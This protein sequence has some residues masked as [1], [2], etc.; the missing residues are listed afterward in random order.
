MHHKEI[1]QADMHSPRQELSNG[2]LEFVAALTF[3]SG[4]DFSCVYT[5]G[6]TIQLYSL[7]LKT[8]LRVRKDYS[9]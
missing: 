2:G 1:D 4:I 6:P 3:S 9:V 5:G 7:P 8:T